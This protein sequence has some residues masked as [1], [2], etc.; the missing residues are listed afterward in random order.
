MADRYKTANERLVA[1]AQSERQ[2]TARAKKAERLAKE[3]IRTEEAW[4]HSYEEW[5]KWKLGD[6][7]DQEDTTEYDDEEKAQDTAPSMQTTVTETAELKHL[8]NRRLHLRSTRRPPRVLKSRYSL[9]PYMEQ[10][11]MEVQ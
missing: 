7:Q 2:R 11:C 10:Q 3:Y 8:K 6:E 5:K 1:V 4:E 9:L